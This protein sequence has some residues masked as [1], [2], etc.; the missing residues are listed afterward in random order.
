MAYKEPQGWKPNYDFDRIDGLKIFKMTKEERERWLATKKT[1][2]KGS[3]GYGVQAYLKTILD[4]CEVDIRDDDKLMEAYVYYMYDEDVAKSSARFFAEGTGSDR[5]S[6]A[7]NPTDY[8]TMVIFHKADVLK[9]RNLV[10]KKNAEKIVELV[11]K[12]GPLEKRRLFDFDEQKLRGQVDRYLFGNAGKRR[13]L[14]A[15]RG[16]K[17]DE[18]D[19]VVPKN[20]KKYALSCDSMFA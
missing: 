4:G 15:L 13:G 8:R 17:K 18:S 20:V 1:K 12:L 11:M 2:G 19:N 10:I 3:V 7:K 9:F 5:F 16:I 6:S 14:P